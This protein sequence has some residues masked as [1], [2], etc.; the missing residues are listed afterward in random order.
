MEP[1]K[2]RIP[3]IIV[4]AVAA[5]AILISLK[6][7]YVQVL[8]SEKYSDDSLNNRLQNVEITP[9]RGIIYDRNN[10]AMAISVEKMS[11]YITPSVIRESSSRDEIVNDIVD[12]LHMTKSEV[13]KIIDDSSSDFAWLKRQCEKADAEKLQEKD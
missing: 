6:L 4:F 12:C 1:R 8:A 10:E 9:N 3:F 2:T 13:N 5:L 11:V 7:F